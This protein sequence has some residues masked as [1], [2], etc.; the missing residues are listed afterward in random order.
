VR[1]V[2]FAQGCYD[3]CYVSG[4]AFTA[5]GVADGRFR[6]FSLL[7]VVGSVDW[8]GWGRG[9]Q[10]RTAK[11]VVDQ[12]GEECLRM[13]DSNPSGVGSSVGSGKED[14]EV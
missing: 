4:V 8:E 3:C 10:F 12:R 1:G 11:L 7:A 9:W 5:R 2:L 13:S 6:S 14:V